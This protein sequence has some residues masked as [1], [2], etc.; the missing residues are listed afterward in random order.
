MSAQQ[1]DGCWPRVTAAS[2]ASG[3]LAGTIVSLVGKVQSADGAGRWRVQSA[4]GGTVSVENAHDEPAPPPTSIVEIMGCVK[5]DGRSL[6]FFV[7]RNLGDD[8]DEATYCEMIAL[9]A[10]PK[11][12]EMFGVAAAM[13]RIP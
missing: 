10:D 12:Q 4:D 3:N 2:L 7:S 8:F 9:Q 5:D 1:E 11:Y 13:A 6:D